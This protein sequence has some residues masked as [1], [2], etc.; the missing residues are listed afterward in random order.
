MDSPAKRRFR[1]YIDESGNHQ[2]TEGCEQ[3][4]GL[5]GAIIPRDSYEAAFMPELRAIKRK[6]FT[7]DP[8]TPVVLHREDVVQ[9]AG[10]FAALQ[11]DTVRGAFNRAMID[12]YR[13][14]DYALICVVVD[15]HSMRDVYGPSARH[16]YHYA[17]EAMFER[18]FYY[19]RDHD[20]VGDAIAES[21]GPDEDRLL[22]KEWERLCLD[23]TFYVPRR[24]LTPRL[25]SN[26]LNFRSK[27]HNVYGLQLADMLAKP[28]TCDVLISYERKRRHRSAFDGFVADAVRS[29]FRASNDGKTVKGYGHKFLVAQ[30]KPAP[31]RGACIPPPTGRGTTPEGAVQAQ[32]SVR[33]SQ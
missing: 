13:L 11:D 5:L 31:L 30:K 24:V 18:Y 10:Q 32:V 3:Y 25:L 14:Q 27:S 4:L 26:E 6:F 1:L 23:G 22:G 21:R 29:K 19:L 15:K 9:R 7:D 8:D 2:L 12:F 17:A 20:G 28:C 33:P 16:P